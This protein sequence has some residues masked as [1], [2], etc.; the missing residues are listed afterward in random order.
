[1]KHRRKHVFRDER[2]QPLADDSRR[3]F[4]LRL[5][6]QGDLFSLFLIDD[7]GVADAVHLEHRMF[8][9]A[10][11]NPVAEVLDLKILP[12]D[13]HDFA[14]RVAIH[15]VAGAVDQLGIVQVERVLHERLRRALR[16]VP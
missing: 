6:E 15:E 13:E 1:M 12:T 3:Q 10:H 5:E 16:V 4:L 2:S 8:D 11:F 7:A 9:L 14:A